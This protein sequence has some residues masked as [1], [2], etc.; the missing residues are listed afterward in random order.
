MKNDLQK[1]V[2]LLEGLSSHETYYPAYIVEELQKS[3][4]SAEMMI[5]GNGIFVEG[6]R[7]ESV[8]PEWGEPGIYSLDLLATIYHL[9]VSEPARSEM[10]GRGFWY[11]DVLRQLKEHL[12]IDT[13]YVGSE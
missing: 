8:T 7:I 9:L 1:T 3:G 5:K 6:I 12:G 13:G 4:F 10:Q 11:R 2:E